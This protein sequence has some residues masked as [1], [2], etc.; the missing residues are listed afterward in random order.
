[1]NYPYQIMPTYTSNLA[2]V[3]QPCVQEVLFHYHSRKTFKKMTRHLGHTVAVLSA[4][5]LVKFSYFTACLRSF[6]PFYILSN[7]IKDFGRRRCLRISKKKNEKYIQR[8]PWILKSRY[9]NNYPLPTLIN[10]ESI[11]EGGKIGYAT[12][13][14]VFV[15]WYCPSLVNT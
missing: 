6:H 11:W 3:W 5:C 4:R 15:N 12:Q 14:P 8:N 2:L 7:Y 9:E 1:M 10:P 13:V